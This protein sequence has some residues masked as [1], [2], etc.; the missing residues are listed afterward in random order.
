MTLPEPARTLWLLYGAALQAVANAHGTEGRLMLGGGTVLAA[1]WK[2]RNSNDIDLLLPDRENLK[3]TGPGGQRDLARAT[4]GEYE[5]IAPTQVKIAF[6]NGKLDLAAIEPLLPGLEKKT[7]VDGRDVTVLANA[8]ILRGKFF[9][10]DKAV[11]RDAFDI[12]VASEADPRSLRIAVN[13]L[14]DRE[15]RFI[16]HNLLTSNDAMVKEAAEGGLTEV[17]PEYQKYLDDVGVAAADA[18]WGHRYTHVQVLATERG[19]RI[20]TRTEANATPRQEDHDDV[21]GATALRDSGIGA[22]LKVNS[23]QEP[24]E[25]AW[26]LD[27]VR[28]K[29]WKGTVFN[30]YDNDPA[31]RLDSVRRKAGIPKPPEMQA[32]GDPSVKPPAARPAPL[33]GTGKPGGPDKG[34]PSGRTYR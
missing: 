18:V 23:G 25:L 30:S 13:S 27:D 16:S 10:T 17:P 21:D 19:I 14:T 34:R 8:Q 22:Y 26:T 20:E 9:R 24:R 33:G 4:G 3:D 31:K 7:N 6:E 11:T 5:E 1:R 15:T 12:A 28:E 32:G 29:R 2:H